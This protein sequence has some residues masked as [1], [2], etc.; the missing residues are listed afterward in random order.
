MVAAAPRIDAGPT[1]VEWFDNVRAVDT[2]IARPIKE[3][4]VAMQTCTLPQAASVRGRNRNTRRHR[5][6]GRRL[7]PARLPFK[8]PVPRRG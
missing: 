8:Q 5:I 6:P 2:A 3:S 1:P 7:G 4:M